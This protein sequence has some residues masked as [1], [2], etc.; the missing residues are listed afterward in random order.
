MSK[1]IRIVI[2][3][4]SHG[5]QYD[6]EA[7]AALLEYC[8]DYFRPDLKVHLGDAFDLRG[9]R[10]GAKDVEARE[11]LK[12]DVRCG[13]ALMKAYRPQVYLLGN[14]ERRLWD[15]T[16]NIGSGDLADYYQG[17]KDGIMRE[18]RKAGVKKVLPYHAD[19]GVYEVGKV[20]MAH[21]YAHGKDA[22]MKQGSHFAQRG[23]AFVCGHI[24]RLEMV[25]LEKWQGGAAF[26]AGCLCRKDMAYSSH[27]LG[28]SRWGSGFIA[29]LI[30]GDNFKLW[31]VHKLGKSGKWVAQT[32][33]KLL[34]ASQ[35]EA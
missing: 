12:E 2:A 13:L 8:D 4:D 11:S 14:H 22:V 9:L 28:S 20:A 10:A 25:A 17:V 35:W 21:G 31:M 32:D 30:D 15:A 6:P 7:V 24:H 23:G 26:S 33:F 5:D 27:R 3:G 18:V 29:G 19:Q 1:P 34:K 16:D